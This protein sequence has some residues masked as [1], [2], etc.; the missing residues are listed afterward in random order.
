MEPSKARVFPMILATSG[1]EISWYRTFLLSSG[2]LRGAGN[3]FHRGAGNSKANAA[4]DT[5]VCVCHSLIDH[6]VLVNSCTL[7]M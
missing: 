5:C 7:S 2:G 4:T 1:E 6:C 3:N